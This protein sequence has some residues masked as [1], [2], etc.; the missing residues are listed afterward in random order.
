LKQKKRDAYKNNNK[1]TRMSKV[2][3][4]ARFSF[5]NEILKSEG[6][7]GGLRKGE[8]RTQLDVYCLNSVN[9]VYINADALKGTA[10]LGVPRISKLHKSIIMLNLV[11][12]ENKLGGNFVVMKSKP[13]ASL[14]INVGYN[15]ELELIQLKVMD[16]VG[17]KDAIKIIPHW[18]DYCTKEERP[19]M[20]VKNPRILDILTSSGITVTARGNILFNQA[21]QI[22]DGND[23]DDVKEQEEIFVPELYEEDGSQFP[24]Q[25]EEN[26]DLSEIV[27]P[28]D[29][30]TI[31]SRLFWIQTFDSYSLFAYLNPQLNEEQVYSLT[32]CLDVAYNNIQAA[33]AMIQANMSITKPDLI[34]E[35]CQP[36]LDQMSTERTKLE[37]KQDTITDPKYQLTSKSAN[38]RGDHVLKLVP[39]LIGGLIYI[40]FV[41]TS[42]S[43][44]IDKNNA[45]PYKLPTTMEAINR[46]DV[47]PL[48][49]LLKYPKLVVQILMMRGADFTLPVDIKHWTL[50]K[51]KRLETSIVKYLD[52]KTRGILF[53]NQPTIESIIQLNRL[54]LTY[55][56]MSKDYL[57][58]IEKKDFKII[59]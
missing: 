20:V 8:K 46:K 10:N 30:A 21:D 11:H 52:P 7:E 5:P 31:A 6:I 54:Y 22:A 1:A 45:P 44:E 49:T 33:E 55:A 2:V 35:T 58:A 25:Y 15:N 4:S 42:E 53:P 13:I 56:T 57:E 16:D 37:A 19:Y 36:L 59:R 14:Q 3:I 47:W 28:S 50:L 9:H 17:F 38:V 18:I 27:A 34:G 39:V 43:Y 24:E 41:G 12:T 40:T 23:M 51:Q 26:E 32:T 48:Y 29:K